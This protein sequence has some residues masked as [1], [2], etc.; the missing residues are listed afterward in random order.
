MTSNTITDATTAMIIIVVVFIE[1]FESDLEVAEMKQFK[2][3]K[4]N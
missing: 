1:L 4:Q 2:H 3:E